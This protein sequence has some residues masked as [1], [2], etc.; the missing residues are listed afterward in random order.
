MKIHS[1]ARAFAVL[2]LEAGE[3]HI[4]R[5]LLSDVAVMLGGEDELDALSGEPEDTAPEAGETGEREVSADD[6]ARLVGISTA[7]RPEDPAV[8]RLLPDVDGDDAERSAEFRRLTEHDLRES[9]LA[10]IR[11]ALYDLSL[12]GRIELDDAHTRAWSMALND[13]R[14]V[15]ATRMSM[16]SETDVEDLYAREAADELDDQQ[17]TMLTVYDFLTWAQERLTT[18]LLSGLGSGAE[19]EEEDA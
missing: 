8:L 11:I 3:K 10:N 16:A 17:A 7:E 14:L 1:T 18:I 15:L 5:S 13:V 2:D 6:L 19:D 12:T 9:K 4:F